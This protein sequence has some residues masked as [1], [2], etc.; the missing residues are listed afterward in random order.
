MGFNQDPLNRKPICPELGTRCNW[1]THSSSEMSISGTHGKNFTDN[2]AMAALCGCSGH[3]GLLRGGTFPARNIRSWT[4][5]GGFRWV[6]GRSAAWRCGNLFPLPSQSES[7][8]GRAADPDRTKYRDR[9]NRLSRGNEMGSCPWFFTPSWQPFICSN[10]TMGN[11]DISLLTQ[12][13]INQREIVERAKINNT[14]HDFN[15]KR[16]TNEFLK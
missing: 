1:I 8:H 10:E 14:K 9:S 3:C 13:P 5:L 11:C 15:K 4:W 16:L 6:P 12:F 7:N 2:W